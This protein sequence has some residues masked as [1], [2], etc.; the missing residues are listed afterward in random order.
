MS[1]NKWLILICV[2]LTFA[3]CSPKVTTQAVKAPVRPQRDTVRE[4]Q[5]AQREAAR[6]DSLKNI[7]PQPAVVKTAR[8]PAIALLL[9][10]NLDDYNQPA[11][12]VT[13]SQIKSNIAVDF[14]QGFKL[15]LDSLTAG[16]QSF[17]LTVFDTKDEVNQAQK[18]SSNSAIRN[19]DL[20]IGPVFPE[21]VQ[22]FSSKIKTAGKPVVSPLSASSPVSYNNPDLITL[23]PPLEFHAQH[24]ADYIAQQLHPKTIFILRSGYSEEN[25]YILPFKRSIDSLGKRRIKIVDV[26]I[27]KGDFTALLPKLSLTG[28]NIFVIAATDRPFLTVTL[29]A[30][31]DLADTYQIKVFGHP[32]WSKATYLTPDLLDKLQTVITSAY[33]VDYKAPETINFI[34]DFRRTNQMEPGEYAIKGFDTG[35][36]FG[37]LAATQPLDFKNLQDDYYDG[38]HNRFRFE[39]KAGYGWINT[40]VALLRYEDYKLKPIK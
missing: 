38:L 5:L 34:R 32:N 14:Y 30:L 10:F 4:Q 27:S 28:D 7:K 21:G 22:A 39:H 3:A 33:Q 8:V 6:R 11:D 9:P 2:A 29:K 31:G 19:S 20:I 23:T 15:A 26:T 40:Y 24:S 25:K 35:M 36:F 12:K 16:G 17:K 18:L 13:A 1:G 37:K